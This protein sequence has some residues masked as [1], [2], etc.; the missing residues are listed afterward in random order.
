MNK[1]YKM[2]STALLT[3]SL[4]SFS[5]LPSLAAD[6][7]TPITENNNLSHIIANTSQEYKSELI[8]KLGEI[9]QFSALFEQEVIDNAGN[10]LQRGGGDLAVKRPNLVHWNTTSP[11]ES[12]IVSDGKSIF[13]FDPFIEQVT[14]YKLDG[15]IANTPILLITT[16]NES[17]WEQYSVSRTSKN[18]YVIHANDVNSRIKTLEINFNDKSELSGFTFLD[19]TGQLSK[20]LLKNVNLSPNLAPSLFTFTIPEGAHLDDQR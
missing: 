18:N 3:F 1:K 20:V 6:M 5:T 8:N 4:G 13:L 15:A 9:D 7:N 11:D 12:L 19:V 14:A 16:N 17:L 2:I 10:V